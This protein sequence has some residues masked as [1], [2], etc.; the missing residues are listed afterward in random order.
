MEVIVVTGRMKGKGKKRQGCGDTD[1]VIRS[2]VDGTNTTGENAE[3]R[4]GEGA[5][6][7]AEEASQVSEAGHSNLVCT[8]FLTSSKPETGFI[9]TVSRCRVGY[10]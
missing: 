2:G 5:D 3:S 1:R 10:K 7:K 4:R 6:A 9:S 8:L